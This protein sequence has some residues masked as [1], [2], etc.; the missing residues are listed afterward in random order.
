M[1]KDLTSITSITEVG[2]LTFSGQP[3][4]SQR[5]TLHLFSKITLKS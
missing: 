3:N 5:N 2:E 4:F 1:K